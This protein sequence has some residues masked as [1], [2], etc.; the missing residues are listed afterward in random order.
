[1]PFPIADSRIMDYGIEATERIDLGSDIFCAGDGLNVS[2][3]DRLS[4]RQGVPG[5]LCAFGI[6]RM[7]HH[8]M[9]PARKQFARHQAE[10]GSRA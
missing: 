2:D 1:M 6:A 10:A 5:V 3:Y 9:A 7:E 8:P 4:L